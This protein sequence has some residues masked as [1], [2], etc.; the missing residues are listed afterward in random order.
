MEY[1]LRLRFKVRMTPR[2]HQPEADQILAPNSDTPRTQDLQRESN[3][4]KMPVRVRS[5]SL[6]KESEEV[7]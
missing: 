4:G 7:P 1:R 3:V 6:Q 5:G 2:D